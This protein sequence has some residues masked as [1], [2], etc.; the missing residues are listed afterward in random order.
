MLDDMERRRLSDMEAWLR[1]ND[2]EF[3]RELED[4]APT[5]RRGSRLSVVIFVVTLV[6]S[7]ALVVPTAGTPAGIAAGL[8]VCAIAVG[9]VLH[10]RTGSRPPTPPET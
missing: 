6:L 8:V 7:V 1:D 10:R 5:R 3:A 2:P 9:W 4:L